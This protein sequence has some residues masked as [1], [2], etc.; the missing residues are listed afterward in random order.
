LKPV[1]SSFPADMEGFDS[2]AE[3]ALDLRWSWDHSADEVWR[4]LDP[5]LWDLTHSPWIVLQ[6]ISRD[7]FQSVMNDPLFR[8]KIDFLVK[9]CIDA[10]KSPAWFRQTYPEAELTSVAYFNLEFILSE[11]LPIYSVGLGNVAGDQLKTASDLGVL[12]TGIGLLK[13]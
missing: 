8:D 1:Y 12:V 6:A 13:Q 11:A 3:L 10:N 5:D 7:D 4:R 9:S 2:L